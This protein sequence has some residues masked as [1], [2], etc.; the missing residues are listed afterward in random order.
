[1][2]NGEIKVTEIQQQFFKFCLEYPK[3]YEKP[4]VVAM[5]FVESL[6]FARIR[7]AILATPAVEPTVE[8][9]SPTVDPTVEPTVQPIIKKR[10]GPKQYIPQQD[11]IDMVKKCMADGYKQQQIVNSTGLT[12]FKIRKCQEVI[13]SGV[14]TF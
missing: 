8:P 9:V 4:S 6:R 2:S 1:M 14:N 5:K 3:K 11:H 12:L 13:R 7:E 10:P